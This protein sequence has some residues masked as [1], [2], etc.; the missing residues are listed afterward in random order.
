MDRVRTAGVVDSLTWLVDS[1][2]AS[3]TGLAGLGLFFTSLG[4]PMLSPEYLLRWADRTCSAMAS[5]FGKVLPH[6]VHEEVWSTTDT[7][8]ARLPWRARGGCTT[9]GAGG[10]APLP[11]PCPPLPAP[12]A[13]PLPLPCAR[14]NPLALP[15]PPP[16]PK[17]DS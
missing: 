13:D 15:A 9:T 7:E 11:L 3:L 6:W 4:V 10:A 2:T 5:L 17:V 12:L 14:V 16:L 8:M 1:L